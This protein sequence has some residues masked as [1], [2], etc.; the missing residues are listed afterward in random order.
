MY[1]GYLNEKLSPIG[2]QIKFKEIGLELLNWPYSKAR[3]PQS[4]KIPIIMEVYESFENNIARWRL[5]NVNFE[6]QKCIVI[7]NVK[8]YPQTKFQLWN[9]FGF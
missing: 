1:V 8:T 2:P 7:E 9:M 4:F 3:R 5:S 6:A